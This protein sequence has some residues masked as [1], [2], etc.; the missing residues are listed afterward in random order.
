VV[1]TGFQ[2]TEPIGKPTHRLITD[3]W[4]NERIDQLRA[5]YRVPNK[6]MDINY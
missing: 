2:I 3:N 5:S 1:A 6:Q 4:T